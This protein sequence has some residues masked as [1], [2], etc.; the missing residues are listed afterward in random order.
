MNKVMKFYSGEE[1]ILIMPVTINANGLSIIHKDSGGKASAT[2]PDVCL[3]VVGPSVVPIP[4]TNS[5][6]SSDLSGG[7]KTVTADGGNSIAIKGCSFSKST[8]DAAGTN[9]G[10]VSGTTQGK[11]EF[12]TSS[13]TVKIEGK[14]VCRLSDQMTMNSMN[15]MCLG[16]AQNPSVTVTEEEEGTYTVD[17]FLSY[18][19][20][21]PVQG[22]SYTL[23]DQSGAEFKGNLN[24]SGKGCLSGIAAG[25]FSVEYTEDTREFNPNEPTKENPRYTPETTPQE[26]L[27]KSKRGSVGFWEDPWKKMGGGA[28]WVWG[29]ILGDFNGDA[30]VEQI[31]AN[32]AIS[33]IPVI[34]Q[35]ADLRDLTANAMKLLNE[36]ARAEP[37]NWLLLAI[38]LIGCIP[39]FG[40]AIKGT[41]KIALKQGKEMP[42]DDLL[43]ILRAMGKGDPEKFLRTLKWVDYGKQA[44][45]ILSDVIKPCYEVAADLALASNK[46]GADMFTQKF[47]ELAD[48]LKILDKMGMDKISEAM[49]HFDHLFKSI[50]SKLDKVFPA[51]TYHSAGKGASQTGKKDSKVNENK[52]GT[53]RCLL[54]E[55]IIKKA[56]TKKSKNNKDGTCVG[57]KVV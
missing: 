30:T 20:G 19:D 39:L 55:R 17:L 11:A 31:I 45:Q 2:L 46:I 5:A 23:V 51:K 52:Q 36:E 24:S 35:V 1:G 6:K 57:H 47:T 34:D 4:Y 18:S 50:L 9:K 53:K 41:C 32:T 25:E 3:T 7:S 43:A 12:I 26:L 10:I 28:S 27:E 15:T 13:P 22:A 49:T 37:E 48:E 21:D 16:G 29:V 40:S 56:G 8:G 42:K 44:A 14:G 54:C 38:T 33:M